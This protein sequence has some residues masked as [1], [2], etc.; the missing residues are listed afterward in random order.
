MKKQLTKKQGITKLKKLGIKT[1]VD[2]D[3]W[4]ANK[5]KGQR[6]IMSRYDAL[7]EL[8]GDNAAMWILNDLAINQCNLRSE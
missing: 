1:T 7:K 6:F 3:N 5:C 4:K 2:L 8:I